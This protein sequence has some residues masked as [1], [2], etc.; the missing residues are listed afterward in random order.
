MGCNT[1]YIS[2]TLVG[3][4]NPLFLLWHLNTAV[5]FN[6]TFI[7]KILAGQKIVDGV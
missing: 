3:T 7:M 1:W 5:I 2:M 4:K 6:E